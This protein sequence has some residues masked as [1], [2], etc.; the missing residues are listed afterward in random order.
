MLSLIATGKT[1]RENKSAFLFGHGNYRYEIETRSS[2][3]FSENEVF[4]SWYEDALARFGRVVNTV[5]FA[6]EVK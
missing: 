6:E 2:E 1:V 3:Y 5:N 4:E